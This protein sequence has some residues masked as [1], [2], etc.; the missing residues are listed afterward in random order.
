MNKYK[1][2]L[3]SIVLIILSGC[4]VHQDNAKKDALTI[5]LEKQAIKLNQFLPEENSDIVFV[6]ASAIEHKLILDFY[7]KKTTKDRNVFFNSFSRQLCQ[8]PEIYSRI[9]Q[10]AGY[11]LFIHDSTTDVKFTK[12]IEC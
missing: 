5:L 8:N 9:T 4:S 11:E 2:I 3:S 1:K 7:L 12:I 6:H 10:G